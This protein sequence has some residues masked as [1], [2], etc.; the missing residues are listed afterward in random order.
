MDDKIQASIIYLFDFEHEFCFYFLIDI[1]SFCFY[2]SVS[3]GMHE[4]RRCLY[5]AEIFQEDHAYI[6]L[7]LNIIYI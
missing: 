5:T 7:V 4:K 2:R 6:I 3:T 1:L